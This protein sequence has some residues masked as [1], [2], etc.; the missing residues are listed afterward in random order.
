MS[1]ILLDIH[2]DA[3]G[4]LRGRAELRPNS[5]A[6][7]LDDCLFDLDIELR[8]AY[9]D[10]PRAPRTASVAS[11]LGPVHPF[12]QKPRFCDYLAR[13][14]RYLV[15]LPPPAETVDGRLATLEVLGP[16]TALKLLPAFARLDFGTRVQLLLDWR[17]QLVVAA[18]AGAA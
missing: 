9:H 5:T 18:R 8:W 10:L 4:A 12:G 11:N 13:L 14:R 6:R 16:R 3:Q 1:A 17:D 15:L 7:M 2:P